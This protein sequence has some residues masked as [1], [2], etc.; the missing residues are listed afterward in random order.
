[1]PYAMIRQRLQRLSLTTRL[2]AWYVGLLALLL[3]ALGAALYAGTTRLSSAAALGAAS[4]E[5]HNLRDALAQELAGGQPLSSVA[6]A[7]INS[8]RM[9]DNLVTITDATGQVVVQTPGSSER[10]GTA[11]GLDV[12]VLQGAADEW[13]GI[14][15][16]DTSA[17][18]AVSI[19]R[20]TDPRSGATLG[21]IQVG[22]SLAES[23]RV[24]QMLLLVVAVG[25]GLVL[26]AAAVVGPRLTRLGLQPLRTMAS[27]SRELAD[28]NLSA[29]VA[30]SDVQDEVGELAR[31]FNEMAARLEANF[32]AQRAF[33]ADASHELR[34]PLTA[35]GGSIDVL[36]RVLDA[37][38]EEA[39]RLAGFMRREVDRMSTLVDDL[40]VLAR[41]DAQGA[42]A[43]RMQPLD[44]RSVARDVYEQARVMPS[45]RGR[46]ISLQ[47]GPTAVSV[48]GE[49]RRL[50]QVLLN[51]AANALEHAPDGGHVMLKVGHCNGLVQVQV[52]DDG[53][54]IPREHL[55]HVFDRFYRTD[56]A[57]A[58]ID[59]GHGLGLAIARAIVEAH[60]GVIVASNAA[61]GGAVFSVTLPSGG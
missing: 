46:A 60:D 11:P 41:V 52:Q 14:A 57:R 7:A 6:L 38:P 48:R 3:L 44:L 49:P 23:D 42:A 53:P 21:A 15:A 61:G 26:V 30:T 36:V 1:M 50:H 56:T 10:L 35:L 19:V 17:P 32:A 55:S 24:A 27:A 59:G 18:L 16:G 39:R 29:R 43:L 31:A 25:F 5:A 9:Q 51:L 12:G 20:L 4:I 45:A 28:G 34:T 58:H 54:G 8:R 37:R 33:V 2:T 13:L 47:V 40:L 22:T